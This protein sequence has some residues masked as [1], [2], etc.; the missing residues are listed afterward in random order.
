MLSEFEQLVGATLKLLADF[1]Y[2]IIGGVAAG[3]WGRP[4]Y[5]QDVDI[6]IMLLSA[7]IDGFLV[8]AK[9]LGFRFTKE[10][11]SRIAGGIG[12]LRWGST[13]LDVILALTEFEQNTLKRRRKIGLFGQ[14]VFII[15]PEDLVLYKLI[16]RRAIDLIDIE[17]VIKNLGKELDRRYLRKW[18]AKLSHD[19]SEPAIQKKLTELLK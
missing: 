9:Q 6:V 10:E 8:K 4:R 18:A 5:T 11:W 13:N 19:L 7:E 15:S 14:E 1:D 17:H 2:M 12:K 16:P 3:V